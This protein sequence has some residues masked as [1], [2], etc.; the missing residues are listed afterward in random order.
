M[1]KSAVKECV[2]MLLIPLRIPM[3]NEFFWV[4]DCYSQDI[5]T[6]CSDMW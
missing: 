3:K 6:V 1:K 2:F 4:Q 5:E